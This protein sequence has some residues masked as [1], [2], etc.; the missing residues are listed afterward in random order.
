MTSII[1]PK[2]R[3]LEK[4]ERTHTQHIQFWHKNQS[5]KLALLSGTIFKGANF[6][7]MLD[8]R[9]AHVPNHRRTIPTSNVEKTFSQRLPTAWHEELRQLT[10]HTLGKLNSENERT[11][12]FCVTSVPPLKSKTAPT[13]GYPDRKA[14]TFTHAHM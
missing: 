14:Q 2:L 9:V 6:K 13:V 12:H 7:R 5:I 4:H 1:R 10:E 8:N 3:L 11:S